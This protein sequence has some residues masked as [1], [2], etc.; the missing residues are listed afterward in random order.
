MPKKTLPTRISIET[1]PIVNVRS[2]RVVLDQDLALFFGLETRVLNQTI[3][4]NIERFPETWAFQLTEK[5]F[6]KLKSQSVIS[7]SGWGGRR[8]APWA[9]SEHGVVMAATIVN[10]KTAIEASQHVIEEFVS[11][12]QNQISRQLHLPLNLLCLPTQNS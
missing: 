7:N 5:E 11:S 12:R 9:F 10:S 1:P 4:R 2:E 6:E 8:S 3:K